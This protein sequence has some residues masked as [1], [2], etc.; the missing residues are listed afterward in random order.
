MHET[1]NNRNYIEIIL[2]LKLYVIPI[3]TILAI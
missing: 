2:Q 3:K 1:V